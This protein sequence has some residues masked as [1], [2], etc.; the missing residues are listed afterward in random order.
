MTERKNILQNL[1]EKPKQAVIN[2]ATMVK[3][4]LDEWDEKGRQR[5]ET[6]LT[7]PPETGKPLIRRERSTYINMSS[8]GQGYTSREYTWTPDQNRWL[9]TNEEENWIPPMF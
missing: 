9:L 6:Y 1:V 2:F 4:R 8:G 5:R 7:T 3:T